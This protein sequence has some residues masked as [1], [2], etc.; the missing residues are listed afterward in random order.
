MHFIH[1]SLD[2]CESIVE[3]VEDVVDN[4]SIKIIFESNLEKV[5]RMNLSANIIC[6]KS[7][8]NCK[9]S[10]GHINKLKHS[11]KRCDSQL[12]NAPIKNGPKLVKK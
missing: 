11:S 1:F 12:S 5:E 3:F 8:F 7:K 10:I 6:Q 4:N 2:F 9:T